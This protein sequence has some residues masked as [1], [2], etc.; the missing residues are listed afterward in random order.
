[1]STGAAYCQLTDLLFRG[2][3]P[4][5]RVKWNSRNHVDFINNWQMLQKAWKEIG[6]DKVRLRRFRII[7]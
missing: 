6:I 7:F 3:I 5:K 1:M 4:L 2:Q